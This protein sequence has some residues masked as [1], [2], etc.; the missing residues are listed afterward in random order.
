MKNRLSEAQM[1]QHL[2]GY[3]QR[4]CPREEGVG[5]FPLHLQQ[6][7]RGRSHLGYGFGLTQVLHEE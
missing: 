7:L 3:L 6:I 1:M 2:E 4:R 5:S